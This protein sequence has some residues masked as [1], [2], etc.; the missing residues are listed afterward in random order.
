MAPLWLIGEHRGEIVRHPLREGEMQVGRGSTNELVLP[1][2]TVSRHHATLRIAPD[3]VHITDLGSLNGT[4]V[5]G[6]QVEGSA[7]ARLGDVVEFGSVLLRVADRDRPETRQGPANEP[8]QHL[9][10]PE[11]EIEIAAGRCHAP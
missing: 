1:S 10:G 2:Q 11:F 3:S 4:R 8:G 7:V 6:K 9:S 5:N